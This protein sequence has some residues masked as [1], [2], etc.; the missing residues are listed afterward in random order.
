M[1]SNFAILSY[2]FVNYFSPHAL[3]LLWFPEAVF[4][5]REGDTNANSNWYRRNSDD[6]D[7]V[8][9]ALVRAVTGISMKDFD[10]DFDVHHS[11][12]IST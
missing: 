12:T 7:A 10:D 3:V 6:D 4:L 8:L 11:A 1:G 2:M 5:E 9:K